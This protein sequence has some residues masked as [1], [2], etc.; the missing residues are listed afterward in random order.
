M[1]EWTEAYNIHRAKIG[2]TLTLICE[3]ESGGYKVMAAGGVRINKLINLVPNL[4]EAKRK[5]IKLGKKTLEES[6]KII[7][8]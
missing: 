5:T 3:W 4:D 2:S 8:S 7:D 1:I 6:L